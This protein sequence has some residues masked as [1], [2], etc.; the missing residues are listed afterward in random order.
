[1][2][3]KVVFEIPDGRIKVRFHGNK[4]NGIYQLGDES[5]TGK[6]RLCNLLIDYR[7]IGKPVVGYSYRD[8]IRK[9][10]LSDYINDGLKMI[11]ID[12]YDMYNGEMVADIIKLSEECI[13]LIDCKSIPKIPARLEYKR[14]EMSLDSIDVL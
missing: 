1:M 8:Y 14:V 9:Q 5:G 2:S 4:P 3:K 13:V 7:T 10:Q 11:V 12:R 6:T